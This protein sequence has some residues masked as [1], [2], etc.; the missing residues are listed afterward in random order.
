VNI[1]R[2]AGRAANSISAKSF[3]RTAYS[4]RG[5]GGRQ[6]GIRRPANSFIRDERYQIGAQ[7]FNARI[8]TSGAY[9]R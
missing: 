7:G 8:N 5:G 1:N 3:D 4:L 2:P 6:K 9:V